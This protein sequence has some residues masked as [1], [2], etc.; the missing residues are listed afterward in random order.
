MDFKVKYPWAE[1]RVYC[2]NLGN[3]HRHPSFQKDYDK[4]TEETVKRGGP[5][6]N[7]LLKRLDWDGPPALPNKTG[8]GGTTEPDYF[9]VD[10][11]DELVRVVINDW[12]YSVPLDVTHFIIWSRVPFVHEMVTPY[13]IKDRVARDGLW[14]F[15]GGITQPKASDKDAHLIRQ[16]SIEIQ[17]FVEQ[18]WPEDEWETAW[19]MNPLRL[20]SVPGLAHTHVFAK[21]KV[22]LVTEGTGEISES[23]SQ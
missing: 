10:I 14:G 17:M 1:Q 5:M 7:I 20:Q 21:P 6:V 13:R 11:P 2:S 8:A 12:P 22:T 16:A 19:F 23:P 3:L 15:T 9:T 4:W 18:V